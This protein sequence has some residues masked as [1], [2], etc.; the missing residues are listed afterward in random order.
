ME[1]TTTIFVQVIEKPA[2]QLIIKRGKAA[3]HYF[4]YCE[5]VGCDV[6]GVLSSIKGALYEPLGMWLPDGLRPAGTS[7]YAQG[8]EVG[9]DYTGPI[10][11][12]MELIA[13]PACHMMVFQSQ[14]YKDEDMGK[15]IGSMQQAIDSYQPAV[16]GYEWADQDA[17]RYQLCPLPERGYIEARPVR[18]LKR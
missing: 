5:E 14:P 16:F 13:L 3:T 7:E 18:A 6:W 10:P 15:I 17:P 2:R 12:G 11:D 8:V 4:E 1:P 9:T